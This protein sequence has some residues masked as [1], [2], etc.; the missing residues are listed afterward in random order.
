MRFKE[1]YV[2]A[3]LVQITEYPIIP[4]KLNGAPA[5]FHDRL[6]KTL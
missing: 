1:E 3:I 4:E 5:K 6:D 2:L